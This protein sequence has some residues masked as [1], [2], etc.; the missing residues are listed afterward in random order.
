MF[1]EIEKEYK[2]IK[3]QYDEFIER[4][5]SKID[6]ALCVHSAP[7]SL[8]HKKGPPENTTLCKEENTYLLKIN[9]KLL[10]GNIGDV[11]PNHESDKIKKC[12]YR[13]ISLCRRPNCTFYHDEEQRNFKLNTWARMINNRAT[14]SAEV[15]L[16]KKKSLKDKQ[17]I[18]EEHMSFTMHNLLILLTLMENCPLTHT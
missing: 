3:K 6:S 9:N 16:F 13:S 15:E 14:L 11:L 5:Y 18:I 17:D 10:Y 4:F 2:K 8:K 1:K 7:V 12:V